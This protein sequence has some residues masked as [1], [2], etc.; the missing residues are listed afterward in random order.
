MERQQYSSVCLSRLLCTSGLA[1]DSWKLRYEFKPVRASR[2]LHRIGAHISWPRP[3]PCNSFA[4]CEVRRFIAFPH[5]YTINILP[6]FFTP[7]PFILCASTPSYVPFI[8]T[9]L[10]WLH[11]WHKECGTLSS[12]TGFLDSALPPG[13]NKGWLHCDQLSSSHWCSR[14][15]DCKLCFQAGDRSLLVS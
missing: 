1:W 4:L 8:L 6:L 9:F 14:C 3:P 13:W 7:S 10:H 11:I 12:G 5:M 15:G 2:L